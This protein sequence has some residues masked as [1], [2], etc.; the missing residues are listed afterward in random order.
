MALPQPTFLP[1]KLQEFVNTD[2]VVSRGL[3]LFAKYHPAQ[4]QQAL[5]QQLLQEYSRRDMSAREKEKVLTSEYEKL[6]KVATNFR[7]TGL[8]PSGK[9][10]VGLG[11]SA[12]QGGRGTDK[13][14]EMTNAIAK[15]F[16]EFTDNKIASAELSKDLRDQITEKYALREQENVLIRAIEN[17]ARRQSGDTQALSPRSLEG[18]I[19]TATTRYINRVDPKDVPLPAREQAAAVLFDRLRDTYPGAVDVRVADAIDRMF[20]TLGFARSAVGSE[21]SLVDRHRDSK[22]AELS[23]ARFDSTPEA[24]A[25]RMAKELETAKLGGAT[26][27]QLQQI[28]DRY[29]LQREEL[30]ITTPL[31][32]EE[33]AF[34]NTY[35]KHLRDDGQADPDEF[36]S[37][38]QYE[39]ALAAYEKAKNVERL[40]RGAAPFFDEG[41][42]RAIG[43]MGEI[44]KQLAGL[45]GRPDPGQLAAQK[46][47]GLPTISDADFA[48]AAQISPLAAEALPYGVKRFQDAQGD[49]QPRDNDERIAL[50]L[51]VNGNRGDFVPFMQQVNKLTKGE[52]D[53]AR[54]MA[55]FYQA[56]YAAQDMSGSTFNKGLLAGNAA[57]AARERTLFAQEVAPPTIPTPAPLAEPPP[58]TAPMP[59]APQPAVPVAD[60]FLRDMFQYDLGLGTA[61]STLQA[62]LAPGS[63]YG[64][65]SI[66][67][68]PR[69]GMGVITNPMLQ[70]DAFLTRGQ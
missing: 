30:G 37:P 13:L 56:Y 55:A 10:G 23:G 51:I 57:E 60:P 4:M 9:G 48:A 33:Q 32:T 42:L 20:G 46:T 44:E 64:D 65:L 5:Y 62:T 45:A 39:A 12:R 40:P 35:I 31:T 58:Q 68:M 21:R 15:L 67:A 28:R 27:D 54:R 11:G 36:E 3:E 1:Y 22:N 52:P 17:E 70:G 69:M 47:L 53:R 61:P 43:R 2:K 18:V 25:L 59:V 6:M 34:L 49:L 14:S 41:Y 29:A 26:A 19:A 63:A 38:E 7:E 66:G 24:F 50:Q 8:G 16:G